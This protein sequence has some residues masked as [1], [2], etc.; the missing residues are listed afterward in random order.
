MGMRIIALAC[1][2]ISI[3]REKGY[4]DIRVAI[5]ISTLQ[6]LDQGFIPTLVELLEVKHIPI[7][8]IELEL[9]ESVFAQDLVY[10]GEQLKQLRALGMRLAIDDFGTGYSSL[11]RLEYL[12]IDILKL[13]KQF[14]DKL[15]EVENKNLAQIIISMAHHI[16]KKVV[17]EGVE[18]AFQVEQLLRIGCDYLQGYFLSIPLEETEAISLLLEEN[19]PSQQ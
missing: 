10:V 16:K 4:E 17:A 14:V 8:N 1:N 5:N 19:S 12:D 11:S 13:D 15:S 9:T 7:H 6:L 2:F 18:T 3:M